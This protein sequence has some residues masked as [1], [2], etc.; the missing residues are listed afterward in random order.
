MLVVCDQGRQGLTVTDVWY[1]QTP[2]SMSQ[3][4]HAAVRDGDQEK[5]RTILESNPDID[6][7]QKDTL[8]RAALHLA[9]WSGSSECLDVLLSHPQIDVHINAQDGMNA[10]HFASMKLQVE[11]MKKLLDAGLRVNSKNRKGMTPLLLVAQ[12]SLPGRAEQKDHTEKKGYRELERKEQDKDD[13]TVEH[14]KIRKLHAIELLLKRQANPLSKNKKQQTAV[15]LLGQNDT[16][17]DIVNRMKDMLEKAANEADTRPAGSKKR[18]Q[19][20]TVVVKS[21]GQQ[22]D[23]EQLAEKS[24]DDALPYGTRRDIQATDNEKVKNKRSKV[25]ISYDE[26]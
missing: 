17:D 5:L 7:N 22:Q 11:C 16:H 9:A 2:D 25:T 24:D 3:P 21:A 4:L 12:A 15:D 14:M 13:M 19:T 1:K 8:Q 18:R 26:D 20:T 23:E 6:V 10:L